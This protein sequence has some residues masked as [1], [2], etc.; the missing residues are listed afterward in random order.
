[1]FLEKSVTASFML[2]SFIIQ[3]A[4]SKD[5]LAFACRSVSRVVAVRSDKSRLMSRVNEIAE[6]VRAEKE[7]NVYKLAVKMGYSPHYFKYEIIPLVTTLFD[8]IT[9]DKSRNTLK[10]THEGGDE[11]E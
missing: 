9:Y 5:L 11:S 7:I 1:M 3:K 6:I 10:V 2:L 8:D 4:L